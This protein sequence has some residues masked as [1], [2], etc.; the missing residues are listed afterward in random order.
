MM[1]EKRAQLD[2]I[3]DAIGRTEAL[4]RSGTCDWESIARVIQV[5]QMEKNSEWVQKY[6]TNDQIQ[7]MQELGASS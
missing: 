4:L 6:F 5:I 7:T 3:V 2:S 1:L